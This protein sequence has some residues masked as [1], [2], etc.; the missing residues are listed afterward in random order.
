MSRK[1][2]DR[3]ALAVMILFF[4][5]AIVSGMAAVYIRGKPRYHYEVR[6]DLSVHFT[7]A[8]RVIESIR[9]AMRERSKSITITYTSH[10]DNM[11]DIDDV[12]SELMH[13][14]VYETDRADEGDYLRYQSG[15]YDLNYTCE[16]KG[17]DREYELV[18]TP[19]LYTDPEQ[20]EEVNE[21]LEQVIESFG[22][23]EDTSDYE[24]VRTVYD[25][26]YQNVDY[27]V[28]HKK[29]DSYH[30]KATAYGALINGHAV[31]QGYAVLMYRM[32]RECGV[33]CRV[34]TGMAYDEELGE[35]FHAWN[36]VRI[37][38]EYY[39][40]DVTWDKQ[41]ESEVFFLKGDKDFTSHK[42]DNEFITDEF[43]EQYPMSQYSYE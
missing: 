39:N 12:V 4:I 33:D 13:Y 15:G 31:C 3:T 24:I 35:E 43:Y 8:D 6:K 26:I 20:E 5:T 42:R 32:L 9:T 40:I 25:Y 30:L 2:K 22:F 38:G 18:I 41:L 16:K 36:I 1:T 34:I 14:A 19:R 37:D 23:D 10:S 7:N 21:K 17:N 29:N 27:D 28:I 11:E